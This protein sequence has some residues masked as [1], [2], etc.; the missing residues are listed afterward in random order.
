MGRTNRREAEKIEREKRDALKSEYAKTRTF[1]DSSMTIDEACGRYWTEVGAASHRDIDW[2]C[3]FIIRHLG[4]DR[5]IRDITDGDVARLLAARR[6]ELV[7]YPKMIAG[8]K[9]KER[10]PKLV[11]NATV[12]RSVIDPLRRI[13]RRAAVKWKEHVPH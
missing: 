2:Y 10:T 7:S 9:A 13:L 5:P 1:A 3:Q 8:K 12:N 4:A 6:K 11:S